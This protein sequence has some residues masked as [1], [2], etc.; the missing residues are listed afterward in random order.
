[1]VKKGGNRRNA[2]A[3]T[4][5][6]TAGLK[7]YSRSDYRNIRMGINDPRWRYLDNDFGYIPTTRLQL[8]IITILISGLTPVY[9]LL[10]PVVAYPLIQQ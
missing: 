5:D 1:M 2:Q 6:I 8:W 10:R 4:R 9:T 7:Y 3:M